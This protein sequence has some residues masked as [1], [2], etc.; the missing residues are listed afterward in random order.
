MWLVLQYH[1]GF[2]PLGWVI[3]SLVL[4]HHRSSHFQHFQVFSSLA[5]F[6]V[7]SLPL[8]CQG[9]LPVLLRDDP[10]LGWLILV[11]EAGDEVSHCPAEHHLRR[12][13]PTVLHWSI[14][15]LHHSSHEPVSVQGA[16][17]PNVVPQ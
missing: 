1:T 12:G 5:P 9:S 11:W 15:E 14:P 16:P 8:E 7:V 4:D 3:A 13:S 6:L 10:V 2:V 17:R